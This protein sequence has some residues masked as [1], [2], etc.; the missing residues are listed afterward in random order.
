MNTPKRIQFNDHWNYDSNGIFQQ[1]CHVWLWFEFADSEILG[2]Y[3]DLIIDS[4]NK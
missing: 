1:L 3:V 2:K 4:A